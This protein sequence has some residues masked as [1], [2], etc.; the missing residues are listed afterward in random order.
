MAPHE[1]Q[2]SRHGVSAICLH[3]LLLPLN[4]CEVARQVLLEGLRVRAGLL[5]AAELERAVADRAAVQPGKRL[6]ELQHVPL[7]S[8]RQVGGHACMFLNRLLLLKRSLSCM[9]SSTKLNSSQE[10]STCSLK[11]S[12]VIC[13]LRSR[14]SRDSRASRP[15]SCSRRRGS[16]THVQQHDGRLPPGA[17]HLPAE[18][19]EAVD[20]VGCRGQEG[21]RRGI[22]RYQNVAWMQVCGKEWRLSML[23][24]TTVLNVLT[25]A[26]SWTCHP[27][28]NSR[29][30]LKE[31]CRDIRAL[32]TLA[33][34]VIR[35]MQHDS[36][37]V[38]M[39]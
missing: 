6:E 25:S 9:L 23:P 22:Q 8:W 7:V 16:L 39:I 11:D 29:S 37:A 38:Y 2:H 30:W 35:V 36:S 3:P 18:G 10:L 19:L 15:S 5:D 12:Q 33:P 1:L 28:E 32:W 31:V 4:L 24:S 20:Q 34:S 27:E 21:A 26:D 13:S 14:V 17:G